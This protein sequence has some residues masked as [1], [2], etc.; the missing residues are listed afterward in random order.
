MSS[1]SVSAIGYLA[2]SPELVVTEGRSYCEFCLISEDYT[3]DDELGRFTVVMQSIWLVATDL[4]GAAIA[5]GARKGDQLFIEGKIRRNHWKA[6][7]T[8]EDTTFIATGFRFAEGRGG[9]GPRAQQSPI[10]SLT[11][12]CTR[13]E[14]IRRRRAD[15][16]G[17][18]FR[19]FR[20]LATGV[21]PVELLTGAL[22][23]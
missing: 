7:G 23:R 1:F 5:D 2:R 13:R 4:V 16:A 18:T 19:C 22:R 21:D 11:C 20:S 10:E 17:T 6:K 8:N 15:S 3:E 14:K 9:P 12:L